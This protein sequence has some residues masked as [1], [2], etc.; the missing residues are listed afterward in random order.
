GMSSD[1]RAMHEIKEEPAE[2]KDGPIDDFPDNKQEEPFLSTASFDT[3]NQSKSLEFK[4]K[5]VDDFADI[6][7]EEPSVDHEST[8][9]KD[10]LVDD[11]SDVKQEEPIAYMCGPSSGS[12]RIWSIDIFPRS[13]FEVSLINYIF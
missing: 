2:F 8:G 10:E 3:S 7:Q 9:F 13:R 1:Y 4:D 11:F 12:S 5:L 6:K